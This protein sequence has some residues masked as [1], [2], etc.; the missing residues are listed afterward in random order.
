MLAVTHDR[1][2]IERFAQRVI[3]IEDGRLREVWS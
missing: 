3:T 2:F 1:Y